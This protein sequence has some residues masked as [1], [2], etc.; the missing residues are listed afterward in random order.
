M[1]A[2]TG[3]RLPARYN[4]AMTARSL[5]E[6][7]ERGV[8]A[9]QAGR[10][11]EALACYRAALAIAPNDAEPIS[12]CG[13]ALL[14]LGETEEGLTRLARAVELEP[15]QAGFRLNLVEGLERAREYERALSELRILA[16]ADPAN[17]RAL[18]KTG[19]VCALTGDTD[20]AV[21]A[22]LR[23]YTLRPAHV[24]PALKAS[25]SEIARGQLERALRILD[26]V[27]SQQ[28]HHA[29]MYLLRCEALIARRDWQG[30]RIT[31][32]AWTR[33]DPSSHA[34]W[35]MAARA[36]FE[37]GF[38]VEAAAAF[39]RALRL[40]APTAA[41]LAAYASLCLHAL[42]IDAAAKALD[43]A[44]TR[45]PDHA[46][47]LS[48][49]ALLLMY[50]GRFDEAEAYCRRCLARDPQ[51]VSA[52]STLSRVRRGDLADVDLATVTGMALRHAV[53]LDLRI[54]AAFI[55]AQA[56]ETR[57]A[58]D[59]AFAAYEYAHELALE[60][61]IREGRSYD[62]AQID[63]RTE[64]LIRLSAV[65][66]PDAV[67]VPGAPRPLFVV[68]MPRAGTTLVEAVLGAHS[69]VFA[70]GER[71]V[72]QQILQAW[73]ALDGAGQV[74]DGQTLHEWSAAYFRDLPNLGN[75][76]HV[77]DK[78]PLN[79]EAVALIAQLFPDAV[80]VN[81]RRDPVE[82]CLSIYCQEFNKHWTFAHRLADIGHY[83]GHYARLAAHWERMFPDRVI[84]IQYEHFVE[85]FERAAPA[86][87]QAC[88]LAWE[89]QCLQFQSTPRAIATFS[90]VQV[91]GPIRLGERRADRY[92]KRLAPLL[93]ALNAG[94]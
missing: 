24:T 30:L 36:A 28:P 78:H 17:V 79:F 69:R 82:T 86:L 29:G 81:V 85:N 23:A 68:G 20:G 80:I 5:R 94:Q 15:H 18:E 13:L 12:L 34:A 58:H 38:Y 51:C 76:S 70:C 53:H 62:A 9:H 89:P 67:P 48:T 88:G 60:R 84:S 71:P 14:R 59:A 39:A 65:R 4:P 32:T 33:A 35:R 25:Q 41:D 50:L 1:H 45:D 21:I 56:R 22:W 49:R 42:E 2:L 72:M 54:P 90:A 83:Y 63:N 10:I 16:A 55:A 6:T 8:N 66:S 3:L 11:D 91:R 43:K 57:G 64:R 61:D 46:E 74:P 19:D 92:A 73:L 44:E 47:T 87:L 75:A 37:L 77:T 7:I 40:V 26:S 93:A 31:A 52:Y 27:A